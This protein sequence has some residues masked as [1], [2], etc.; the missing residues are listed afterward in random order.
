MAPESLA[1]EEDHFSGLADTQK[2]FYVV[3]G[4]GLIE[5]NNG[6]IISKVATEFVRYSK[7]WFNLRQPG[8]A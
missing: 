4:T 3:C 2:P 5:V 7:R 1:G 6:S 8:F